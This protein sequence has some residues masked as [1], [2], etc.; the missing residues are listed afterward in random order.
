MVQAERL[1][2]SEGSD[3]HSSSGSGSECKPFILPGTTLE[4]E[5]AAKKNHRI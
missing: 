3:D 4:L 2:D 1:A 5:S